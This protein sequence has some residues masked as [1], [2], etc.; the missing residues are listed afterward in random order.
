MTGDPTLKP[1]ILA[2]GG[3]YALLSCWLLIPLPVPC[4]DQCHRLGT[5][6]ATSWDARRALFL[7]GW[8]GGGRFG[9]G[10]SLE[11]CTWTIK[12]SKTMVQSLLTEPQRHLFYILLGRNGSY[13]A[14]H[15]GQSSAKCS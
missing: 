2:D 5:T 8:L 13:S 4:F 3:V 7:A 9:E 12:T 1:A 14:D 11:I 15:G 6:T 10:V